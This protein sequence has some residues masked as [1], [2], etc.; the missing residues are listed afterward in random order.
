MSEHSAER[1]ELLS[2]T[3]EIVAAY[4]GNNAVSNQD[5]PSLISTVF[6]TVS[7]L[8]APEAEPEQAP[9][10]P[11]TESVTK[12]ALIC[13]ECGKPSKMLKRHLSTAHGL[14]PEAYRMKWRLAPNYP[15]VSPD[16][17]VVRRKLAKEIGLGRKPQVR[18]A[19]RRRKA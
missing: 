16:Y 3:S 8:G 9:A 18:S 12:S 5:L 6:N 14:S 2:M 1:S 4:A 11:L 10:V 19:G 17:S 7:G 13:L 15:M